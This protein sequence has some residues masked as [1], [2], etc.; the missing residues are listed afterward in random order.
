ME[1]ANWLI[2]AAAVISAVV[3]ILRATAWGQRHAEALTEAEK[4][5]QN[6]R[7]LVLMLTGV[8]EH[9]PGTQL[10]K[11]R[12]A[13]IHQTLPEPSARNL[14]QAVVLAETRKRLRLERGR[15]GARA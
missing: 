6:W 1:A 11:S 4:E 3:G 2:A 15:E 12:I 9:T 13:D 7:H 14:K 10:L 5:V 8:I